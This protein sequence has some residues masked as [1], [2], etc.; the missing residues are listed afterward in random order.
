MGYPNLSNIIFLE[1]LLLIASSLRFQCSVGQAVGVLTQGANA[2]EWLLN[3]VE[4]YNIKHPSS[5]LRGGLER[6]G[7]AVILSQSQ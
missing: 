5:Q 3:D 4:A 1:E 7:E 6:G 2:S